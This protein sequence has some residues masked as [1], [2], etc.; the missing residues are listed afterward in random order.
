[1]GTHIRTNMWA[2]IQRVGDVYHPPTHEFNP[3]ESGAW[4]RQEMRERLM[5]GQRRP[6]GAV[7]AQNE[8]AND[9]GQRV[10]GTD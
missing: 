7:M 3:D 1:M 10:D 9:G 6:A 4:E 5:R 8:S 2:P